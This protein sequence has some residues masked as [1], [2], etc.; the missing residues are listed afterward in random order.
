MARAKEFD[1]LNYYKLSPKEARER[2]S[3]AVPE[4]SLG[5]NRGHYATRRRTLK[6]ICRSTPVYKGVVS[7]RHGDTLT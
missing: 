3:F 5:M 7:D 2:Y 1:R 4:A 6:F